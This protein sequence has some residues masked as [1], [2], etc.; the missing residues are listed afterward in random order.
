MGQHAAGRAEDVHRRGGRRNVP[1]R[2]DDG[3]RHVRGGGIEAFAEVVERPGG[4]QLAVEQKVRDL[5]ERAVAGEVFD[6]VTAVAE[7]AGDGADG[8]FAGDDA[9]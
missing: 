6:R 2:F 8:R 4:G 1:D 5:L 7:P 9:F 3:G